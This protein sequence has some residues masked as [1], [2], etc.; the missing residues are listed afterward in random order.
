SAWA[1]RAYA[2]TSCRATASTSRRMRGRR[3]RTSAS[4]TPTPSRRSA[5]I[6]PIPTSCSWPTSA[7]TA[8]RARGADSTRAST[9]ARPDSGKTWQ[10]KLFKDDKTGAVDIGIDRRNPNVM[11]AAL[12]EAY[13]IE[14][15]MSSGG[16]GSGLYKSTDGGETWRD[17]TRA[18]GLPPGLVGKISVAVSGADSNRVYA[19]VENE[20]GG[21]LSS[22]DAGA[23]WKVINE[24]R[25]IRQRAFYYTHVFAEPSNKDTI[26]LLN[27]SAFRSIDGGKT[28]VNIGNGTHGDHHD[29]WIDPDDPNH[30]MDGNDG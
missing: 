19:L 26:Y 16:P 3:G 24:G 15:Q 28:L 1:S 30:V 27:T 13:R 17:I 22:D 4:A 25:N 9:A 6:R 11:Y 10:R 12:W 5:F 20:K 7:A 14:Y 8:R 21:L 23:T 18:P 29:F 2:A